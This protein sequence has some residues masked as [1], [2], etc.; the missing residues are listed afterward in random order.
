MRTKWLVDILSGCTKPISKSVLAERMNL[1]ESTIRNIVRESNL[2]GLKNGFQLE[3]V[4]GQGYLLHVTSEELFQQFIQDKFYGG[5]VY[6]SEQRIS[7]II[8]YL[9]QA[10]NFITIE[11]IADKIQVS[12]N[13]IVKDL[14]FVDDELKKQELYLEKR[15]HYGIRIA[16]DESVF[17]R[18][19]SKYMLSDY[20]IT[21]A[22]DFHEFRRMFDLDELRH[23]LN[24]TLESNSLQINDVALENVVRHIRILIFRSLKKN[25]ISP[26]Q[27]LQSLPENVY[28]KVAQSI[29]GWAKV[30]YGI[31]LPDSEVTFLATHIAGKTYIGNISQEEKDTIMDKLESI[32]H[33][34]DEEFSTFFSKDQVLMQDLLFHMLPLLKRLYYNLQLENPL[35]DEI[36][37]KYANVFVIAL[38]Y[39]ES[40][41][42]EYG[43]HMSRDEVGYVALHFAAHFERM[44]SRSLERYKRIVVICTTGGGSA[45]LLRLKLEGIF[46]KAYIVTASVNGLKKYEK[47][48][49]DLF[50]STVP[51]E[52]IGEVPTIHIKQWLDEEEVRRIKEIVSYQ[53]KSMKKQTAIPRLKELF[54]EDLFYRGYEGK[55]YLE[56]LKARSDDIVVKG[57]AK[58]G[59]QESVMER[60]NKFATIY[61]NGIAGPH[62]MKLDAQIDSVSV[63]ILDEPMEWNGRVI[64]L[65]FLINLKPGH[66][67]LHK[68]LSRLLLRLMENNSLRNRL[69]QART[70]RQFMAELD[71]VL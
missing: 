43:F 47:E 69:I 25:F 34:L 41:E 52:P 7:M 54:T 8:A 28:I 17:R 60:E 71:M 9:L 68:E 11:Q 44:K 27:H 4:R 45:E 59:F 37:S 46:S 22:K 61:Q 65:V 18:A 3:L 15:V 50:L 39:S 48:L 36:Y 2:I 6:N 13:T 26:G 5:D 40:I 38:R 53:V 30:Q 67:F 29:S 64:Q 63:T 21:P 12:R 58:E 66:L 56:L 20:C 49:P 55:E 14:K 70:F 10:D 1:S 16:G 42:Q 23:V 35:V 62:A 32:T 57:Y 24:E 19:F 51:I 31:D 33:E